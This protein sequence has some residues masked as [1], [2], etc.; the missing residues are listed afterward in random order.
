R[1]GI[2]LIDDHPFAAAFNEEID[3]GETRPVDGTESCD[4]LNLNLLDNGRGQL[5]RNFGPRSGV[6]V[7]V[8]VVVELVA[9]NDLAWQAGDGIVIAQNAHLDFTADD[10][11]LDD[12]LSVIPSRIPDRVP[13]LG[14]VAGFGDADR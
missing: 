5:R 7:F 1:H 2:D 11:A 12:Y 10:R 9:G 14:F 13:Q 6:N 8:L 3:A 4:C